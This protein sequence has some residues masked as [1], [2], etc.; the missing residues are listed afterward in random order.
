MGQSSFLLRGH[1]ESFVDL[2]HGLPLPRG[3]ATKTARDA[4]AQTAISTTA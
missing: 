1:R 3:P 2:G 4:S